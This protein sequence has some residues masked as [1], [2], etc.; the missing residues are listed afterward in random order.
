MNA[1]QRQLIC[2]EKCVSKCCKSTPPA[3]TSEDILK[4]GEYVSNDEWIKTIGNSSKKTHLVAKKSGSNDCFF[5][6]ENN[7]CKIYEIRPLDCKLFPLFVK[8]DENG[9]DSYKVKWLIWYCPLTNEIGE[10]KLCE[11]AKEIVLE[12]IGNKPQILFEY[13]SSMHESGGYKKKHFM[14]EEIIT[15][16]K[17]E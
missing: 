2:S 8:L 12:Y 1:H 4:I 15:I 5:L 16:S 3:L 14:R 7:L 17:R 9:S 10:G 11:E 13:Q 6:T